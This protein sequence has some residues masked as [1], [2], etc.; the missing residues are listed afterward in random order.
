MLRRN[1]LEDPGYIR[2]FTYKRSD[3]S[4]IHVRQTPEPPRV[5]QE[6]DDGFVEIYGMGLKWDTPSQIWRREWEQFARGAFARTLE[7][8]DQFYL[9]EHNYDEV[10]LAR[11]GEYMTI[12]EG[13]VGLDYVA[14]LNVRANQRAAAFVDAVRRGLMD[15]A[16]I[17]FSW[18]NSYELDRDFGDEDDYLVTYTDV[19]RLYEISGVKW[20]AHESSELGA[21]N[22]NPSRGTV[23]QDFR[24][25]PVGVD[26]LLAVHDL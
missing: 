13:D 7:E 24:Y 17:G 12:T 1:L 3:G 11:T 4:L 6:D 14:R 5:R 23:P 20:P 22:R 10:P 16:S 25:S 21:R 9:V 2:R 18:D 15:K 8:H 19:E 26:A